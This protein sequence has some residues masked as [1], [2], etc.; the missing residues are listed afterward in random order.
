MKANLLTLMTSM[1]LVSML[2][3]VR[4]ESFNEHELKST[5][6]AQ[7]HG[8]DGNSSDPSLPS[9]AGQNTAYL[10]QQMNSFLKG[11]RKHPILKPFTEKTS[12]AQI[13]IL[14]TYYSNLEAKNADLEQ[15]HITSSGLFTN[16]FM[17]LI[18]LGES[19]YSSCSGCHGMEAEGI[20]PYPRLAD[21]Q[22]GYLKQQLTHFKTGARDNM[23]MHMMTVNLSDEDIN[24]L[25]VY[26]STLNKRR[27][28]TRTMTQ[29]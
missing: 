9:L 2:S 11:D 8:S 22:S 1:L 13:E 24:A 21:Q 7:C 15:T 10:I 17:Q 25:V 26:L 27:F 29:Q 3:P 14:A 18:K 6:C 5:T 4:S 20:T 16:S 23:I 12:D 28:Q 19:C